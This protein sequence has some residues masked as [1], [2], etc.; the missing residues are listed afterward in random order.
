MYIFKKIWKKFGKNLE[1]NTYIN[2]NNMKNRGMLLEQIINRT[3]KKYQKDNLAIFHKKEIP[4]KFGSILKN[5]NNLKVNNAFIM[6]KSTTDYYGLYNG[7]FIAFEAKSTREKYV[8]KINFKIHQQNYLNNI[9]YHGGISFYIMY[10]STF[11]EFYFVEQKYVNINKS[12]RIESAREKGYELE[13]I[14]PG[15]LNILE[16]IDKIK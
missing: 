13:I 11:N 3:I 4:I 6:S 15:L 9:N 7:N 2:V 10:F 5:K 12:F 14:Y 16:I 8:P 1:K